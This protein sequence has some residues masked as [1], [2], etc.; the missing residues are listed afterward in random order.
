[1]KIKTIFLLSLTVATLSCEKSEYTAPAV[2]SGESIRFGIPDVSSGGGLS[3][4]AA[5]GPLD[6][7]PEGGSFGVLGYCLAQ[8][9]DNT[10]LDPN[11]GTD[12]WEAKA[13]R[14]T[15]HL[16]YKTEV[17]YNGSACY[18]T[19]MQQRWYEP[20]DYLYSFFAYYPYEG[21]YFAVTPETAEGMGA[22]TLTF[23]MPFEGGEV[24]TPRTMEEIPD[25]MV[26]AAM[27]ATRGDGHVNL[28]FYHMLVGLNFKA[29]NYNETH[30]VVIHGLRLAGTFHRSVKIDIDK[31]QSYPEETFRGTFAF[32]DGSDETDDVKVLAHQSADRLGDKVLML[33][34]NPTA[35]PYLGD[36]EIYLDYTFMGEV[37]TNRYIGS[38]ADFFPQAG[39]IYTVELNFI[40]DAFVLNFVVDN[41]QVWEDGGDSDLD[42]E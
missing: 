40:G 4:R 11:T 1:M 28:R 20:R 6:E 38:V 36:I 23:S 17:E 16:F 5:G 7:F 19:G 13:P 21:G 30:G 27:D 32:L 35:N 37:H 9:G 15:P 31:G 29:N 41:N 24:E 2:L 33:V 42:F 10:G 18:Y 22:P 39:T 14:S 26:A 8:K 12:S 34:S 25:A 3:S